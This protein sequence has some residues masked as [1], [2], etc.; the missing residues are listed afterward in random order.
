MRERYFRYNTETYAFEPI[1]FRRSVFIRRLGYSILGGLM[2]ALITVTFDQLRSV[3]WE[4]EL[5]ARQKEQLVGSLK[6]QLLEVQGMQA[7]L[8]NY[9]TTDNSFYRSILGL[10]PI[11]PQ[12]WVGGRGGTNQYARIESPLEQELAILVDQLEYQVD[13]QRRSFDLLEAE[14]V[15]KSTE[16]KHIPA[17]HPIGAQKVTSVGGF[18]YRQDPF[19]GVPQ[20]HPAIDFNVPRGTKVFAT[21]AGRVVRAGNS[22]SGYGVF[23][24]I[25]HGFG[26]Q[27]LYAHLTVNKVAVGDSVERGQLIGLSG[28][29]GYSK[30]P[31]LHYEVIKYGVKV[32]PLDYFYS[33]R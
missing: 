19:T 26:Y 2:L 9:H 8:Y 20:Y 1:A 13:Y 4:H 27:S 5:I 12:E 21:G 3:S 6:N 10:D 14:A 25:D 15:H 29:T 7:A 16:L 11:D 18:G 33:R 28:N 23:V 22:G 24:E 32:N 31:H 30:G 17:I